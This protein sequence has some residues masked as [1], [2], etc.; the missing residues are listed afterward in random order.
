MDGVFDIE[1]AQR[2][3]KVAQEMAHYQHLDD[4]KLAKEIKQLEKEMLSCANNLEF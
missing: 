4:K 2:E 3:L 1:T